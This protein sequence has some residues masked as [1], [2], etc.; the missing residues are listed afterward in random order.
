[1]GI[2]DGPQRLVEYGEYPE[3]SAD[4]VGDL[5][6]IGTKLYIVLFRWR[7]V[8]GIYQ[9][10]ICGE[11]IR[12]FASLREEQFMWDRAMMGINLMPHIVLH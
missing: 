11:I 10:C 12:S 4:G 1:M 3:I 6:V 9:R 5:K 8:D 7:R 2:E